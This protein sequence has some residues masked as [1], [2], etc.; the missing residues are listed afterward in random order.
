M[1]EERKVS[2]ITVAA[3]SGNLTNDRTHALIRIVREVPTPNG[4]TEFY[5]AVKA[6]ALPTFGALFMNIN[7]PVQSTPGRKSRAIISAEMVELGTTDDGQIVVT[8]ELDTKAALS[9]SLDSGQARLLVDGLNGL[10]E[11]T[12]MAL[13]PK[14]RPN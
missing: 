2:A 5:L 13:K 3:I 9:F 6:S 4:E 8:Y 10:L 7:A 12:P 1:G 14:T 11:G